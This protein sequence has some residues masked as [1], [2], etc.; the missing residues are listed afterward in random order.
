VGTVSAESILEG[1]V[2]L[3]N[4]TNG[5]ATSGNS[6]GIVRLSNTTVTSNTTGLN[7]TA[8]GLILTCG[9]NRVAGNFVN[10][11]ATGTV[12]EQWSAEASSLFCR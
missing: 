10:G 3:N 5:I 11:V 7:A 12:L 8:G 6:S 4:G 1:S 2:D 9:S